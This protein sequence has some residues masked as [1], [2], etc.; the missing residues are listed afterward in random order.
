[1]LKSSEGADS[2]PLPCNQK[3]QDV[4][5]PIN[6]FFTAF[7]HVLLSGMF[8]I[9]FVDSIISGDLVFPIWSTFSERQL[10]KGESVSSFSCIQSKQSNWAVADTVEK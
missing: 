9:E 3:L 7:A 4:F 5:S 6:V 1:M 2:L 8:L 10:N